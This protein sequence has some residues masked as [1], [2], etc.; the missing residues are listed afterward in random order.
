MRSD[1]ARAVYPRP[2]VAVGQALH[3]LAASR[4][5]LHNEA[6]THRRGIKEEEA[7]EEAASAAAAALEEGFLK[8]L[9]RCCRVTACVESV[10]NPSALDYQW[11][12]LRAR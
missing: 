7:E 12:K 10:K 5:D 4:A 11:Y 8:D 1:G 2:D 3:R 6:T 9:K